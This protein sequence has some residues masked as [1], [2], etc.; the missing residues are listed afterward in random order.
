MVVRRRDVCAGA[1]DVLVEERED[2]VVN[3]LVDGAAVER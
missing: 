1:G 2:V 3:V